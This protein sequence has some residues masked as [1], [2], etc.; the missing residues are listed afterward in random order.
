M[1]PQH[2]ST[3]V[4]LKKW[5]GTSF[6]DLHTFKQRLGGMRIKY[7]CLGSE[8]CPTTG[9]DHIQFYVE[10]EERIRL[11]T[12]GNA[13]HLGC[14]V[15]P[16]RRPVKAAIDYIINNPDKPNPVFE[17]L[18]PRPD[19]YS[20]EQ[21]SQRVTQAQAKKAVNLEILALTRSGKF[22]IIADKYPGQ[23]LRS[24]QVLKKIYLD[25]IPKPEDKDNIQC[26]L[27]RG[28]SGCGKTQFLKRHFLRRED[29]YWYNKN[30]N[31]VEKYEQ[32]TT[33]VIDDLDKKH[34]NILNELK[35]TCDTVPQ[36]FNCKFGS[37]WSNVRKIIITTQY[38]WAKLI[39]HNERGQCLDE[40]LEAALSRRFTEFCIIR[41]DEKTDDVMVSMDNRSMMF[42]ISLRNYLLEINFI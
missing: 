22:D 4:M 40:E 30:P 19:E 16:L 1:R 12:I 9:R 17:E 31:F 35:T 10:T 32:Q 15:F 26:I 24:Y 3:N 41:R 28:H 8:V 21:I 42:P 27:V 11:S 23:Y 34:R 37:V 13:R 2:Q 5:E 7:A 25:S 39:G 18:G 36:L 6:E 38:T 33:L 29:V 14:T 20:E